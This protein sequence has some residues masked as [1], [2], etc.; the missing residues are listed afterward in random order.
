[1]TDGRYKLVLDVFK[2]EI[3]PELYD[4]QEDSGEMRNLAFCTEYDKIAMELLSALRT[5]MEETSDRL[6]F[7]GFT[8]DAV[9]ADYARIWR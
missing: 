8:F 1:M 2:D 3:F 4:L 7:S 5:H 6:D 9:R